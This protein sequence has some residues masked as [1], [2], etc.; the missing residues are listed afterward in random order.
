MLSVRAENIRGFG[1]T[2][3]ENKGPLRPTLFENGPALSKND[4][5]TSGRAPNFWGAG[6]RKNG[7]RR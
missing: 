7:N 5:R 3:A 2:F 4:P 1:P 6:L